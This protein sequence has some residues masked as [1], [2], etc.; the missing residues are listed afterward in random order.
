MALKLRAKGYHLDTT[1]VC[2]DT[3]PEILHWIDEL[4][5]AHDVVLITGGLGPT[6]DDITKKVLLD[7]FGGEMILHEETMAGINKYVKRHNRNLNELNR[8]Q[9]FVPSSCEVLLNTMGSAPGMAFREREKSV[10]AMPG[11]PLEMEHLMDVKVIPF[12]ERHHPTLEMHTRI[13]RMVGISEARIAEKM[14]PLEADFPLALEV[15][16]L[17][18]YEGTKVELRMKGNDALMV[19]REIDAAKLKIAAVF[20]KYIYS[21]EDK[22]PVELVRDYLFETGQTMAT[23]ESCTGGAIAAAMVQ[24]SGISSV[25]KG[26]VVAY[27]REIKETVLEVAPET[28]DTFGIVSAEVAKAM[29]RG[30]RKAIGSDFAISITGI[31]EA[32]PDA[33]ES[34]MPQ[35]W[36]GFADGV[37][38]EAFYFKLFRNRTQ[39]IAVATQAA[40]IFAAGSLKG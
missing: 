11:V 23:A 37:K 20:E 2:H 36:I 16:Y 15:A 31:A 8:Q 21:L 12:L 10:I 30:A 32:A 25:F 3:G 9:A 29:A 34:E 27:M 5:G 22:R 13:L 14:E 7:R 17:P 28:I 24:Q 39:N 40:L 6:K 38:E 1:I 33:P 26:G 4:L 19:E 35:C 18:S